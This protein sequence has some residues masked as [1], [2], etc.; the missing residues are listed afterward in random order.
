MKGLS[1]SFLVLFS[2]LQFR[3]LGQTNN[4]DSCGLDEN[5]ILNRY[6]I[7]YIDTVLFKP[8]K[9]RKGKEV[10]HTNGFDFTNKNLAFYSCTHEEGGDG[11]LTKNRFFE[12]II[13]S[14]YRGPRDLEVL[15]EAQKWE[16][17]G[18][19]AIIVINCKGP[20]K[21]PGYLFDRLKDRR[22]NNN[23]LPG[24]K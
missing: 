2:L 23:L 3:S 18:F 13:P 5:S 8:T 4:L 11:F 20:F 9:V 1:L 15:N 16:S 6:E 10:D 19:D 7:G 12:F 21:R 17:G 14:G 24:Q 22:K